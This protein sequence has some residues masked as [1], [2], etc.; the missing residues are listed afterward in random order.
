MRLGGRTVLDHV[1]MHVP[2][3]AYLALLGSTGSG[4]ST[5]A[6]LITGEL[7]PD[8]GRVLI[9]GAPAG[10]LAA[11]LQSFLSCFEYLVERGQRNYTNILLLLY[12]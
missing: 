4:K 8:E 7:L 10:D 9:D 5:L 2:A 12:F 3:G 11:D 6:R 1:D